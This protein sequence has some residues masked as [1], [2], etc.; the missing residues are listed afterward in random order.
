MINGSN[1][2]IVPNA[3]NTDNDVLNAENTDND[4]LN[5]ENT[6]NAAI[7]ADKTNNTARDGKKSDN[8]AMSNDNIDN[9]A[10]SDDNI[11]NTTMSDENTDDAILGDGNIENT[12][13]CETS[14]EHV[15]SPLLYGRK[16]TDP[17]KIKTSK[18]H[19]PIRVKPSEPSVNDPPPDKITT[20][21]VKGHAFDLTD[22]RVNEFLFEAHQ[23]QR[24][25]RVLRR[26]NY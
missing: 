18:R 13:T 11:D 22:V 9:A 23:I 3:E 25:V 1:T 10:M 8:A 4:V 21:I 12:A 2:H 20:E 26:I 14:A 24:T 17:S 7:N 16:T 5:A 6:D 15:P 19:I